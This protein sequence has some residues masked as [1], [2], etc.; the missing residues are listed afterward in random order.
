MGIK[1]VGGDVH[2]ADHAVLVEMVRGIL[3]PDD[4]ANLEFLVDEGER[5]FTGWDKDWIKIEAML[6]IMEVLEV[7]DRPRMMELEEMREEMMQVEEMMEV[8]A[9]MEGK[10][11]MEREAM[12]VIQPFVNAATCGPRG[13]A[14]VVGPT[15]LEHYLLLFSEEMF[16]ITVQETNRYAR[17]YLAS[18]QLTPRARAKSW[19]P[20]TKPEMKVLFG[21]HF[22]TGNSTK[23][24]LSWTS[25]S[26]TSSLSMF[27][28]SKSA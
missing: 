24:V 19:R 18:H 21:L 8:E 20:V 11:M 23:S 6:G 4:L 7:M 13:A 10:A 22:L 26:Q 25:S 14:L 2:V 9:M 12:M 5:H 17:Q 15:V 3:V 28:I 16:D 1:E 27:L